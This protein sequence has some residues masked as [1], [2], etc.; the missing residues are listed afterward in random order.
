MDSYTRII[1]LDV[2]E[3]SLCTCSKIPSIIH[4]LTQSLVVIQA[5]VQGCCVRMN[6]NTLNNEQLALVLG[7][8]SLHTQTMSN[9]IQCMT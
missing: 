1:E 3:N 2:H 8:I 7:K 4:E 9:T 5:Y 6:D